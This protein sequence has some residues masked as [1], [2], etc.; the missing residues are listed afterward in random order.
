M[1][2]LG[3][4]RADC[5]WPRLFGL[6]GSG[7]IVLTTI[8]NTGLGFLVLLLIVVSAARGPTREGVMPIK[9][10]IADDHAPFRKALKDLFAATNDIDVVAECSDGSQVTAAAAR[11]RPDVVLMDLQ[12]PVMSGLE[13]TRELLAAQPHMRVVVLTAGISPSSASEA[14][15]LGAVGYLFKGGDPDEFLEQVRTVASG[16]TAWSPAAGLAQNH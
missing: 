7:V 10:L 14:R 8:G 15:A 12:M 13:A 16:G 5:V 9:V 6:A 2:T 3:A 4:H 11:T 1:V